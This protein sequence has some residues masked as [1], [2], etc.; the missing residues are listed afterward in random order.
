VHRDMAL[1]PPFCPGQG[2]GRQ[3]LQLRET[4]EAFEGTSNVVT[5]SS[6]EQVKRKQIN[7][8]LFHKEPAFKVFEAIIRVLVSLL[9][10]YKIVV[11]SKKPIGDTTVKD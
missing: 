11:D 3:R 4:Q 5:L 8:A 7:T 2:T 10:D 1:H 6:G 9:S